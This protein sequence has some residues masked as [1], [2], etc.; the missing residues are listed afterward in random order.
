[1]QQCKKEG[2]ELTFQEVTAEQMQRFEQE[3]LTHGYSKTTISMRIRAIRTICNMAYVVNS[4]LKKLTKEINSQLPEEE[5][6]PEDISI[7]TARHSY[8]TILAHNRVPES[9]IG[10]VLGHSRKSVTDSYIEEYSVEDRKR[11][12]GLLQF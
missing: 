2:F 10:F 4:N 11:Y 5:Q 8:G 12:N 6:L 7:Y 9:Y 1:M 3:A